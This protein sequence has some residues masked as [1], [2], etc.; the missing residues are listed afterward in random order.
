MSFF[1]I[2]KAKGHKMVGQTTDTAHEPWVTSEK[3]EK[4]R[5]G[6]GRDEQLEATLNKRRAL[7]LAIDESL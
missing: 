2:Q 3:E 4:E 5:R 1:T 7:D 6:N